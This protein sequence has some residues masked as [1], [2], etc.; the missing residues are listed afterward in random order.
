MPVGMTMA[1]Y[2]SR[3]GITTRTGYA[4]AKDGRIPVK[5]YGKIIRVLPDALDGFEE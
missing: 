4:W 5:R 2:C 1:E 3:V